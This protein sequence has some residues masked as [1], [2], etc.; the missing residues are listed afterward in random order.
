MN[1]R[2]Y[3]SAIEPKALTRMRTGALSLDLTTLT[4]IAFVA[5]DYAVF[6]IQLSGMHSRSWTDAD[7]IRHRCPIRLIQPEWVSSKPD[8]LMNWLAAEMKARFSLIGLMWLGGVGLICWRYRRER[9][10]SV[11][12]PE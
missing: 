11:A 1:R 12:K 9:T 2:H 6:T 10:R 8:R 3:V 4:L 7:L 5:C